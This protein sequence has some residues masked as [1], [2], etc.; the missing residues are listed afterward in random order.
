[1]EP[2][3]ISDSLNRIKFCGIFAVCADIAGN[4]DWQKN[5][6]RNLPV[7]LLCRRICRKKIF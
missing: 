5:F 6:W 2:V 3:D 7:N 4:A 1:M